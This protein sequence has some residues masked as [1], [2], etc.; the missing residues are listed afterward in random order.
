MR[1]KWID[2]L[3]LQWYFLVFKTWRNLAEASGRAH[4][5][6]NKSG[7]L[8]FLMVTKWMCTGAYVLEY[9]VGK[10][11]RQYDDLY[12]SKEFIFFFYFFIR[13]G[14]SGSGVST[15]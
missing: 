2:V 12:I 14:I 10:Y 9:G 6:R 5:V 8:H 15:V 3:E 7:K 4:Y 11:S 13:K 1:K